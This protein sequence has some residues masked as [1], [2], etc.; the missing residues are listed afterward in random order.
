MKDVYN[1]ILLIYTVAAVVKVPIVLP[2]MNFSNVLASLIP[3][4]I[5]L[6]L[7]KIPVSFFVSPTQFLYRAETNHVPFLSLYA[8]LNSLRNLIIEFHH[9]TKQNRKAS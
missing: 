2:I 9:Y 3:K 4:R 7:E 8:R 6:V 1:H 5:S